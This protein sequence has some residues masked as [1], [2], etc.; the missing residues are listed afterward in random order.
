MVLERGF[1][2]QRVD[3]AG[4]DGDD[5]AVDRSGGPRLQPLLDAPASTNLSTARRHPRGSRTG[6]DRVHCPHDTF[7]HRQAERPPLIARRQKFLPAVGGYRVFGQFLAVAAE[8]Q[9]LVGN[10][11]NL[12]DYRTGSQR[13]LG[14][15][16]VD[17]W[18]GL[19]VRTTADDEEAGA[20]RYGLRPDDGQLV[21]PDRTVD[22][23]RR[24]PLLRC[25]FQS[26]GDN[27]VT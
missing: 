19:L 11:A 12:A 10:H 9:R 27:A 26:I 23:H 5:A 15:Q 25:H 22:L 13:K 17:L 21:L 18:R 7:R 3:H 6:C 14:Q 8:H 2:V 24:P 1:E 4:D 20:R 16:G